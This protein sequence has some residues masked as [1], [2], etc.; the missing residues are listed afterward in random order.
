[1][2]QKEEDIDISRILEDLHSG[3]KVMFKNGVYRSISK[4]NK[5]TERICKQC[6]TTKP[7]D[8]YREKGNDKYSTKCMDCEVKYCSCC[9]EP[10]YPGEIIK[11]RCVYC[12]DLRESNVIQYCD[13]GYIVYTSQECIKDIENKREYLKQKFPQ[14]FRRSC[15]TSY[16]DFNS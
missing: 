2:T 4:P 13:K 12:N 1:M 7:K 11:T 15:K 14:F 8:K 6:N 16:A 3:K 10:I 5:W 9:K